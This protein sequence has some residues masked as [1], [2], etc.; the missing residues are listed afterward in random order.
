MRE[1]MFQA[2]VINRIKKTFPDCIILKNDSQYVQGIPDLLILNNDRWGA[3]EVKQ[4]LD[5][6]IGANQRHW[7]SVMG[8]MSFAAFVCPENEEEVLYELQRALSA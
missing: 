7:V 5:S 2:R 3:L 4:A 6:H 1:S 8:E